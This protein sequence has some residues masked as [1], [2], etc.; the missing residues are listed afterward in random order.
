MS[1][2]IKLTIIGLII[3]LVVIIAARLLYFAYEY[4]QFKHH[5]H[6]PPTNVNAITAKTQTWKPFISAIGT[7]RAVQG[8]NVTPEV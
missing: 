4:E 6:L 2:R 3:L 7:L 1:K 5:F 8:V